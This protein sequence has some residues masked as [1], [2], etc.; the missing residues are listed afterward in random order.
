VR[1][2]EPAALSTLRD[3]FRMVRRDPRVKGV[4][5]H[6]RNLGMPP[7]IHL[8]KLQSLRDQIRELRTAGKRVVCWATSYD[9]ASYYVACA[10]EKVLLQPIGELNTIGIRNSYLFLGDALKRLGLQADFVQISPYKSAP[11]TLQRK[12]M[13]EEAKAMA[14]WLLDSDYEQVMED[15][16]RDRG[17]TAEAVHQAIDSSPL[18]DRLALNAGLVD[19]LLNEDELGRHLGERERPAR[20]VPW[21]VAR[22]RV[23]LPPVPPP[24]RYIALIR[25]EGDIVDG[26]SQRPPIRPPVALPL[27][28]SER[29]GDLTVVQHARRAMADRRAAAVVVF[30]DSGGG[31]ATAS[32]AMSAALKQTGTRKPVVAAMG[33]LAASG[34]Y[35]VATPARWIV[36]QPGTLTGSIGVFSGK[37]VNAGALKKLDVNQEI[38]SRGRHALINHPAVPYGNE[39][40]QVMKATIDRIYDVFLDRVSESRRLSRAAVDAVGGG[41][42]WTGRQALEHKLIDELGGVDKAIRKARNLVG[43]SEDSPVRQVIVKADAFGPAGGQGPKPV[44]PPVPVPTP[45]STILDYVMDGLKLLDGGRALLLCPLVFQP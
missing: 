23:M 32:E 37:I 20:V 39:E 30:I 9:M 5:L 44:P 16:A 24:G 34:G 2:D 26:R 25:I 38:L 13:S 35:Y 31:S 18:T 8:A 19:G 6:L 28:L 40:R 10:A 42:V 3:Q 29:A 4:V 22:R 45:P 12:S 14:S 7:T 11:D 41:R 15:I 1:R 21:A 27:V 17:M 36:A 43:L 33:S